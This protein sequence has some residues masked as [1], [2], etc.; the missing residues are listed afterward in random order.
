MG[1]RLPYQ[2][3]Q[4]AGRTLAGLLSDPAFRDQAVFLG[5]PRGGVPVAA[6]VANALDAPLDVFIVRKLGVPG[7]EE[8]AMGAIASGGVI[9]V[10]DDV[11]RMMQLDASEITRAAERAAGTIER[12]ERDFRG[13]E[14]AVRLEGRQ[15][16]LVDDG[17][18]TG[19][20]M[21]AAARAI[22]GQR[23]ERLVIAVPV[24]ARTTCDAFRD[25]ADRVICAA[26]PEPFQAVGLWYQDFSQTTDEHV[27]ALLA[28]SRGRRHAEAT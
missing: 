24:G 19:A 2:D 23:P 5:L 26:T 1:I 28:A 4:D 12:Q 15:V 8:L 21:R 20:T 13:D 3:R 9:V 11:M 27:R 6:E 25:E 16:I 18:A 22:R 14:P 7:H 17:L 10:N